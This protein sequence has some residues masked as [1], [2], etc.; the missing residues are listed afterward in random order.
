MA[1]KNFEE[2]LARLE[3]ITE[4]LEK[5]ELSLEQSLKMFNEGIKL[6]EFCHTKLDEA[7]GQVD[8]LL[9]KNGRMEPVPFEPSVKQDVIQEDS[10]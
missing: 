6:V 4:V 9:K 8:L 2:S 3:E 7:Q 5:G 10:D 1:K